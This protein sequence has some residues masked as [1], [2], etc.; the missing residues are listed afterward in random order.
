MRVSPAFALVAAALAFLAAAH[1]AHATDLYWQIPEGGAVLRGAI[2]H[3]VTWAIGDPAW[4][5]HEWLFEAVAALLFNA[6]LFIVLTLLCAC[7]A[8]AAPLVTYAAARDLGWHWAPTSFV[9]LAVG[10]AASVSWAERPQTFAMLP[11][12]GLLWLLWRGD[13]APLRVAALTLIWCN[14]HGSGV[15]AP[16]LCAAFTL[17]YAI[18]GGLADARV[19]NA[20]L[21]G[22]VSLVATFVTPLGFG[23]WTYARQSLSDAN[24]SHAQIVEWMSVLNTNA[25][26]AALMWLLVIALVV[27]GSVVGRRA[28]SAPVLVGLL[29]LAA[30]LVHARFASLAAAGAAPVIVRA[31]QGLTMLVRGETELRLPR[32]IVAIPPLF[33]IIGIAVAARAPALGSDPT[34]L[35]MRRLVSDHHVQGRIFTDYVD[36]AYLAAFCDL[37]VRVMIDSHGDPFDA[38][39][40]RDEFTLEY[41]LPTWQIAL[42][43]HGISAVV[44]APSHPLAGV[45]GT[46]PQWRLAAT[47]AHALLFLAATH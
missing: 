16:M 27:V 36:E 40:W 10:A 22:G 3:D 21:A 13:A 44:L 23:L 30:P 1:G 9:V 5:D 31:M 35:A 11:F 43:R 18:E 15:L 25:L 6:H 8:A 26:L 42:H 29:F 14:V 4:I 46:S 47:D 32:A 24:G 28:G 34:S 41:A 45:L 33:V 2:P 12:I 20:L 7:A 38:Q 37:P 17:A 39:A 19:R